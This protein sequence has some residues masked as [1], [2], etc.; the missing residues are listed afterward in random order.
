MFRANAVGKY[1][2]YIG[3]ILYNHCGKLVPA[4]QN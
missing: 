1:I 4:I 3:G 2:L